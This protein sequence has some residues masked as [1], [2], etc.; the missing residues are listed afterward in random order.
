MK[1]VP[2]PEELQLAWDCRRS[3][4]PAALEIIDRLLSSGVRLSGEALVYAY[5]SRAA[6]LVASNDTDAAMA[7]SARAELLSN[8]VELV[9]D[10]I[11]FE[12]GRV[13]ARHAFVLNHEAE[14]LRRAL[15]NLELAR[16]LGDDGL[17][18][19]AHS[20]T[21]ASYGL[22]NDLKRSLDHLMHSLQLTPESSTR[23]WA[24]LMNNLGVVYLELG[25]NEEALACFARARSAFVRM[26][27][28]L[29]SAVAKANEGRVYERVGQAEEALA[30]FRLALGEFRAG[31]FSV[32][33]QATEYKIGGA[34][35]LLGQQHKAEEAF[36]RSLPA[37]GSGEAGPYEGEARKAYAD[38]LLRQ[39]RF[40]E[41]IM[42][43]ERA[44]ELYRETGSE[45]L[46]IRA[47]QWLADAFEQ[48]G[49]HV[50]ALG[51]LKELL[52]VRDRV[53]QEGSGLSVQSDVVELQLMLDREHELVRVTAGALVE[54]NR[55]L[56]EQG[57]EMATL[58]T[59]DHL[60]RLR[61][62]RY[63]T[64]QLE[65]VIKGSRTADH[66][67]SIIMLD[68]DGFKSINDRFG[69]ELG[70]LALQKLSEIFLKG[71]RESDVVARWGGEEFALLLP[72]STDGDAHRIAEKLRGMVEANPWREL[73]PDL[74]LTISAGVIHSRDF[75]SS[76]AEDLMREADR[77]MYDAK[78]QGR[79]RVITR[80]G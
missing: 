77:L 1:A 49:D 37:E 56:A 10:H 30:C 67:F 42:H 79:N 80:T 72:G 50:G 46:E 38:F 23:Q 3:D 39:L 52:N 60:T 25:R 18:G 45:Q 2:G 58:A 20:D 32:F 63:F 55:Q 21:A 28:E 22:C 13:H 51:I 47:L 19:L 26:G 31:G 5:A 69:H 61:N 41:A 8:E 40:E 17:L 27:N 62:R 48:A 14:A 70:D 7:A 54:A 66:G 29:H 15:V 53:E 64:Q 68:V 59:T 4:P 78:E 71:V 43:L 74:H 12:I 44:L 33:E 16:E 75:P 34:L 35:S 57:R 73:H 6:A 65:K 36:L 11:R 9:D 76:G 24:I